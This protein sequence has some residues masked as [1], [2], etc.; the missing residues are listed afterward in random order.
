MPARLNCF[1]AHVSELFSPAETP[2]LPGYRDAEEARPWVFTTRQFRR[3][4]AWHI[5]HQPFGVVAG[6]RQYKHAQVAVFEGYAGTSASGFA[7][8][9][10]AEQ[11]VARLDYV[12]GLYRDWA[13]G[14]DSGGGAA[15][16]I[17]AEFAC[18]RAELSDLP[19]TVADRARLRRMLEH[20][21]TTLHPGVLGDCFYRP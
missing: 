12:E 13:R 15:G 20:L 10:E 19:G 7:A 14:G 18:I 1:A 5:A 4:L 9:V 11:A 17:D 2:F 21:T 16:G 6:A 3:T 8:E